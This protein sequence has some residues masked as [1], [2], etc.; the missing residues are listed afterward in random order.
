MKISV[1]TFVSHILRNHIDWGRYVSKHDWVVFPVEGL[2]SLFSQLD[3]STITSFGKEVAQRRWRSLMTIWHE[4]ASAEA[5]LEFVIFWLGNTKQAKITLDEHTT[6][7]RVVGFHHLGRKGSLF[8]KSA[9]EAIFEFA[10]KKVVV[11]T[12]DDQ[13]SFK[14][15]WNQ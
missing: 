2:A 7:R 5:V 12:Q 9:I 1:N 6:P 13:F 10:K 11:D 8:L 3:D 15:D 4:G 14:I